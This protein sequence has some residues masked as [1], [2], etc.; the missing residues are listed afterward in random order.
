MREWA[1]AGVGT[2]NMAQKKK[3]KKTSRLK[4]SLFYI[5][6][7]VVIWVLAFVA[8]LYWDSVT[9]VVSTDSGREPGAPRATRKLDNAEKSTTP[10]KRSPEKIL[11]EDRKKLE[12]ILKQRQ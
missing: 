4:T 8:W 1:E 6:V 5:L 2:L 10:T 3:A 11:D 7:P 12:D 9:K